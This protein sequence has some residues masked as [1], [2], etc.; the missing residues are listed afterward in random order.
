[1]VSLDS[2]VCGRDTAEESRPLCEWGWVR[3]ILASIPG[4]KERRPGIHCLRMRVN[5]QEFW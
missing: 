4:R 2:G 3:V 1:M 5:Y